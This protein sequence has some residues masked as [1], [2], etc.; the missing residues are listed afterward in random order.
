MSELESLSLGQT[1]E[2]I[3]QLIDSGNGDAGRLYHILEYLKNKKP[4]YHTDQIYLENKLNSSFE[5]EDEFSSGAGFIE[6]FA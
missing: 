4:L 2:K 6:N 3:D 1:I 5:V